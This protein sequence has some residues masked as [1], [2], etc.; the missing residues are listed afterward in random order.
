[1]N[2]NFSMSINIRHEIQ[3]SHSEMY[4]RKNDLVTLSIQMCFPHHVWA[5]GKGQVCL[6]GSRKENQ[7]PLKHF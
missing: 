5:V 4:T 1:M 2:E 7:D 6:A 3:H